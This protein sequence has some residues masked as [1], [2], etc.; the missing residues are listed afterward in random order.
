M[1]YTNEDIIHVKKEDIE[2]LQFRKL[3]DYGIV[4]AYV[5]KK[6]NRNYRVLNDNYSEV[7]DN[8]K[9]LFKCLNLDSC[10][11]IRAKQIHSDIINVVDNKISFESI[12]GDALITREKGYILSTINADCILFLLYDKANHVIA[13]VHSGWRGTLKRIIIKTINRMND[14]YNTD[15]S[16]VICCICPC[17]HK[18]HFE[19]DEDVYILFKNEFKDMAIDKLISHKNNKWYIDTVGINKV[20]LERLGLIKDNI[21][22]SNICSVCNSDYINSYRI[23]GIDT[24]EGTAIIYLQ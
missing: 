17:I 15:P 20:L 9:Y 7:M 10:N 13:N 12:E 4:H 1:N 5:L 23:Q 11:L 8:Y 2:Y 21:I 24:M 19:V 22:D 16:N 6:Y 3:L 14:L 18:C